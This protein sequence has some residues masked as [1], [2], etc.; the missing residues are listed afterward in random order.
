MLKVRIDFDTDLLHF[1]CPTCKSNDLF[2]ISMPRTCW[3]CGKIYLFNI[4]DL[5]TNQYARYQHYKYREVSKEN[6]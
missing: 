4:T 3:A 1:I 6:D 2:Y 5:M